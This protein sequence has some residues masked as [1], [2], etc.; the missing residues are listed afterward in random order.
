MES[1]PEKPGFE[2]GAAGSAPLSHPPERAEVLLFGASS[3]IG[4][5]LYRYGELPRVAAFCNALTR[6]PP[7]GL[8]GGIDLDDEAA[9][10]ELFSRANPRLI[11][12]C[13]GICNVETCENAPEFAHRVNVEATRALLAHAPSSAR[14]VYLSSEHVFSG[15]GGPYDEAAAPDPLSVYG[16]TRVL[17]EEL[18]LSRKNALVLRP[19]LWVGPSPTGRIG[20][21]DWLRYRHR[22][23]LPMTVIEDEVRTA[24]WAPDAARRVA[25]LADS[26][27]EGIRHITATRP[28][29]RPTLARHLAARLE[30]EP[31]FQIARRQDRHVPHPGRLE[32][33]T[34]YQD[35]L[36]A[37]LPAA[38][39]AI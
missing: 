10:A 26:G 33:A 12:H 8:A 35:A 15:D 14:I 31:R 30:I 13:A 9:V 22:R 7:P 28:V 23:G 20:H 18:I 4:W 3:I 16:K 5:S 34:R 2:E 37:P 1:A 6:A 19:G 27:A 29:D 32:L 25:A 38:I 11:V 39:D 21:L 36:A 24:V 17:A